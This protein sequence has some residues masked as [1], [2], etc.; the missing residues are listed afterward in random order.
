MSHA[1][2]QAIDVTSLLSRD[3]RLRAD[4]HKV[5]SSGRYL[6]FDGI[7][8]VMMAVGAS[9]PQSRYRLGH[10]LLR[11][12]LPTARMAPLL[13]SSLHVTL[14]VVV[15]RWDFD[16]CQAYNRWVQQHHPRLE[17][18]K[19]QYSLHDT[20][21]TFTARVV[22]HAGGVTLALQPKAGTDAAQ[23]RR[24]LQ[25]SQAELGPAWKPQPDSH[26]TLAYRIP[27]GQQV[28]AA[29]LQQLTQQLTSVYE[30]ADIIV[31][32]PRLCITTSMEDFVPV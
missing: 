7:T 25:L 6:P 32:A 11:S 26:L 16:S 14:C 2:Q 17:R 5:D 28:S 10:E 30:H 4:I 22:C 24:L 1:Q 8:V 27:D 19:L 9:N 15:S 31:D 20:R 3:T 18:L 12:C 21:L 13:T 29:I 23:L